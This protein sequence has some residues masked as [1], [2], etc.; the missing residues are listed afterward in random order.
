MSEI[1]EELGE[2]IEMISLEIVTL[3]GED[4]PAFGRMINYLSE[5]EDKS[6]A[7]NDLNFNQLLTALQGYLEKLIL[8]EAEEIKPF[9]EGVERLQI[10][11]R[12]LLNQNPDSQDISQVL[13]H[14]GLK[15]SE[16]EPVNHKSTNVTANKTITEDALDMEEP[17]AS[18]TDLAG[19]KEKFAVPDKDLNDEE[20]DIL[21]G[22]VI[23]SLENLETIEVSLIDLE[24]DPDDSESIN[25]IFRSFHTIKGVSSFLSLM[26]I[27]R[28]SHKAENLLD[29]IR[30]H[31]IS[32]SERVI[33]VILE[34]VDLLKSLIEGVRDG[35]EQGT[36]FDIALDISAV[37]HRIDLIQEPADQ[38]A[39]QIAAKP[40][41]EILVQNKE[42]STESLEKGLELQKHDPQKKLGQILVEEK[43]IKP[44]KVVSALRD[45]KKFAARNMGLQVKVDTKKLDNLV[46]L[47]GELVIAQSM[48]RQNPVILESGDQKLTTTLG[49]ITR[50]TSGLQTLAMSMRMV[51]IKNTFKKMHRL[52]RDLAKNSGKEVQLILSGEETEIDRN[53]VDELY[54]PMVHMIRNSVD[55]GL[56]TPE[57]RKA[58]KKDRAGKIHL[59]AFYE[60]G[61]VIVEIVD[62][63]KG[64]DRDIILAKALEKK[65]I[66]EEAN[67]S[68]TE[69]YNMIFQPG[70][71]TAKQ[72]TDVSGRGVGM[73]VVRKA[74]EKLRGRVEISTIPGKG[75]T[76]IISLPLTLA[77]I[78]GMVVRVGKDRYIIPALAILKS[79]QPGKD[80][81]YTV[82]GKGEMVLLREK[83]IPLIRLDRILGGRGECTDPTKGLVVA[84]E[85]EG[86]QMCLLLDELLGKEEVVIKSLGEALN[87]IKG[88]AGGAIMG[89]GRIG[90]ILDMAGLWEINSS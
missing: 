85:Y 1:L 7:L 58:V 79:F 46:E 6:N 44:E 16:V 63:G 68:D 33:D 2:I 40:I 51:P 18:G 86:H 57:D 50:I 14:L 37:V 56:E 38:P 62:D 29:K 24:Q 82:E 69:I 27:N 32:I 30:S 10:S 12:N 88:I 76:F 89:D 74:I 19:E 78:E 73:D 71:S 8:R 72:I 17:Q 42:I 5:I 81:Y 67:L 21:S 90:L 65:L 45:Q 39:D 64:L 49:Q 4:I 87:N 23:E 11:H 83:L 60:G 41:G 13:L 66:T 25:S 52:V 15:P 84:V 20:R 80:Q 55:H 48:L 61:K 31:E 59:N 75:S 26:R 28:L 47:S 70:F 43:I 34:S 53:M 36:P 3:E 54:E 9:E 77:I 35:L 22:F